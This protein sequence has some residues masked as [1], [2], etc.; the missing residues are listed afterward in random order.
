[1]K[2][3]V[4]RYTNEMASVPF[5][6]GPQEVCADTNLDDVGIDS[7]ASPSSLRAFER[8]DTIFC[9]SNTACDAG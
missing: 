5:T 1:M 4:V 3:I 2:S 7:S 9:V 8:F 6:F